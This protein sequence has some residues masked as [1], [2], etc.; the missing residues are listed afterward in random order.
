MHHSQGQPGEARCKLQTYS[1]WRAVPG[2]TLSLRSGTTDVWWLPS[3]HKISQNQGA[4]K[5][6]SDGA[7]SYL[8]GHLGIFLPCKSLSQSSS[9]S[10]SEAGYKSSVSLLT[11][12]NANKLV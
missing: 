11:I 2:C 3:F 9:R 4:P 5:G 10:L 6:A 7:Y 12:N 1:V 8:A